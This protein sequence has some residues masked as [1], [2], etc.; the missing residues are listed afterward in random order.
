MAL[1]KALKCMEIS[2]AGGLWLRFGFKVHCWVLRSDVGTGLSNFFLWEKPTW[3]AVWS[4][5][6]PWDSASLRTAS[7]EWSAPRKYGP[8]L[9]ALL[10]LLDA[11]GACDDARQ[12]DPDASPGGWQPHTLFSE[13]KILTKFALDL[14]TENGTEPRGDEFPDV[15][16]MWKRG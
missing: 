3:E 1:D 16:D 10:L 6:D 11:E 15:G 12:G 4:Y 9:R 14:L 2:T 5:L 13:K 7:V 8:H